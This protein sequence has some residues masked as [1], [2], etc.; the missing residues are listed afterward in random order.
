MSER[1]KDI[2]A[3]C[4]VAPLLP[5]ALPFLAFGAVVWAFGRVTRNL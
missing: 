3:W 4:L 1:A 5:F 2:L